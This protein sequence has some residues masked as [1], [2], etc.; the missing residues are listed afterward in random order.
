MG[1]TGQI[2]FPPNSFRV[3]SDVREEITVAG[4]VPDNLLLFRESCVRLVSELKDVGMGPKKVLELKSRIF[5]VVSKPSSVGAVPVKE[6]PDR[7]L[8]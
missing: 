7:T 4:I 1:E 3:V 2:A 5:N 8:E 6:F